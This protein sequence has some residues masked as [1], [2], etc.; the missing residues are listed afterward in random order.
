MARYTIDLDEK[1][2]QILNELV[3]STGS[4]T[5]A[6]VI[7]KAVASYKFLKSETPNSVNNI[8]IT[9]KEGKVIKDIILP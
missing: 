3:E 1:F 7:R 5:K 9:T 6:D 2:D 8:S 4:S